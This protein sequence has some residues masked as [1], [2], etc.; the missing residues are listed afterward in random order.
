MDGLSLRSLDLSFWCAWLANRTKFVSG[1]SANKRPGYATI[2]LPTNQLSKMLKKEKRNEK[3]HF[4][5][6]RLS[7]NQK[8]KYKMGKKI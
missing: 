3:Q 8:E 4:D 1:E 6:H 7:E 5:H 2:W